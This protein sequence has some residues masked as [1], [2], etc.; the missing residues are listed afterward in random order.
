MAYNLP[1]NYSRVF[2]TLTELQFGSQQL[3]EQYLSMNEAFSSEAISF[4][5][6]FNLF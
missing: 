2:Q 4:E 1:N 5:D 6:H 3:I